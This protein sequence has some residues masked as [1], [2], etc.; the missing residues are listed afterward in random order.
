[1]KV[2]L[3]FAGQWSSGSILVRL[4]FSL[5]AGFLIGID[6]RIKMQKA[7]IKTHALVCVGSA[8]AMVTGQYMYENFG[9]LSDMSRMGAQVISGIGFLGVGTI[10]VTG[11]NQV[12]GLTTA[13]GIW[14]CACIGLAAG[15][16]FLEGAGLALLLILIILRIFT[17]IDRWLVKNMKSFDL[18]IEF[19][20][21][22]SI[23]RFIREIHERGIKVGD[24]QINKSRVPKEGPNAVIDVELPKHLN[25][26][27]FMNGIRMLEYID[28]I[29]EL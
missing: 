23:G 21:N 16:G 27:D 28:Y 29:E 18:Y 5:L 9:D 19:N 24:I 17:K 8:L 6:R 20:S 14:A 4:L 1:M 13:A 25:R 12:R 11:K 26:N 22:R 2:F 15:I 7:G 10:I 3:D